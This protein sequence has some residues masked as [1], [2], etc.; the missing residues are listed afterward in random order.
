MGGSESDRYRIQ[1]STVGQCWEMGE[2]SGRELLV[3]KKFYLFEGVGEWAAKRVIG[4]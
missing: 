2:W 3:F 1:P 4:R